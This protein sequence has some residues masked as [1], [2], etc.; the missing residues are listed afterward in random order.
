VISSQ[1]SYQERTEHGAKINW[2]ASYETKLLVGSMQQ[3][4]F[5]L[6][7]VS[8]DCKHCLLWVFFFFL[9]KVG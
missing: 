1:G 7:L 8:S 5:K 4:R 3:G 6:P 9:Q 2:E